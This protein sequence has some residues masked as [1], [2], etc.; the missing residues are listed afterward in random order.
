MRVCFLLLACGGAVVSAQG[1][2]PQPKRTETEVLTIWHEAK[3][4]I[5]T[6]VILPP[7][8]DPEK[9]YSLIVALHGYGSSAEAFSRVGR[10]LANAGFIVA[11]PEAPYAMLVDGKLGYDWFLYHRGDDALQMR[12]GML[13]AADHLPG[14]VTDLWRRYRIGDV[15]VLGFSQGAIGAFVT[16]LNNSGLFDGVVSFGLPAFDTAWFLDDTLRTARDLRILI[17]HGD[18]DER[19]PIRYLQKARDTL[20]AAGYDVTFRTFSGGHSVPNNELE[21]VKEWVQQDSEDEE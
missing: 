14:V 12:A 17:I 1:D 9:A 20:R 11:I 7:D 21:Y 5:P 10:R 15:Y 16:G 3:A 13:G 8:F 19:A 2:P 4:L 6:Q 18:Q